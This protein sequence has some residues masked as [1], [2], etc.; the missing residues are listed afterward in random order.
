M[1]KA[2]KVLTHGCKAPRQEETNEEPTRQKATRQKAKEA[3][4]HGRAQGEELQG[5][6]GSF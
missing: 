2:N 6:T 4:T 5:E 3:L 1:Q